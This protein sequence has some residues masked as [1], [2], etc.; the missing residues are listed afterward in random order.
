MPDAAHLR[1]VGTSPLR[2]EGLRKIQGRAQYIDDIVFPFQNEILHGVTIRSPI[3]RGRLRG[4]HFDPSIPWHEFTVVTAQDIASL[5]TGAKNRVTLIVD[6]QPYLV[7]EI[8]NHTEEPVVL[9]A[10]PDAHQA[11]KA[12]RFVKLDIEPLPHLL[13][14]DDACRH[15]ER[16]HAGDDTATVVWGRD[17]IIKKYHMRKGDADAIFAKLST[18]EGKDWLVV[19]GTYE[20]GAQEQLYIENNGVVAAY[21]AQDGVTIWGSMQCPYYVHKALKGLFALGDDKVRIIQVETGGGFGGKEDYPSILA[22]HAALLAH[23]AGKPVKMIYDRAEDMAA[24]TKRHPSKTRLRTVVDPSG[25]IHALDIDFA[26]DAGAYTTL[27]PVVLSRGTIHASGPYSVENINLYSQAFATNT[28]PHG[29]FRGFGAPQSV[30]ALERHLDEVAARLG[31]EPSEL[32]LRNFLRAGGTTSTGQTVTENIDLPALLDQGLAASDWFARRRAADV[33]NQQAA[34]TGSPLRKG[35]GL[36]T[37]MHGAGFTG[38]GEK[39]LASIA[40]IRADM[41]GN[42]E[43]LSS[44]TE[45]GQGTNTVFSQIA[46]ETL[47]IPF[48]SVRVHQPD[49]LVVPNSG[50]TVASRTTMIVGKLVHTASAKLGAM[51]KP[52]GYTGPHDENAASSFKAACRAFCEA[53]ASDGLRTSAQYQQP[54]GIVWDDVNY[55][56]DAYATYAWAVYI[57]EITVNLLDFMPTVDRFWALQEVG[58]VVNPTLASGQIEGGVVQ[59]I[60]YALYEKVI[61]KNGSMNNNRLTNY[62]IPTSMD[63][64]PVDVLF[65]ELPTS[66]GPYGA[67]GIGEL[68]MDGPAPAILNAM[69]QAT[70]VSY[71]AIPLLPEDIAA[72][73]AD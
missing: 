12:R 72:K 42:V 29:A 52:Y 43:V 3:P 34:Q 41:D 55:R 35:I 49:T 2:K 13:T 51:L 61:W 65:A 10:H 26:I 46:A 32:R 28:P 40:D 8:I 15:T 39:Y 31:I 36:A 66:H 59:G 14:L 11:E 69:R 5:A 71:T 70:G 27:S 1:T 16:I 50:P 53:Q 17:N 54:E 22:G 57:A 44:S 62:I 56:G 21:D 30:F 47:G 68:P 33:F 64:P 73:I 20:T 67:K 45:I 18:E 48:E 38:T 25:K 24:T 6:D 7:D 19:E 23:K 37:F 58:K 9:I 63:T 4:I 60:G